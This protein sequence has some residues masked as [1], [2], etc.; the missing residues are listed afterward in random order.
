MKA[1]P[2]RARF[3]LRPANKNRGLWFI[4]LTLLLLAL[5]R[6]TKIALAQSQSDIPSYWQYSASGRIRHILNADID[7]NGIDDFVVADENGRVEMVGAQGLSAAGGEHAGR[8]R[9]QPSAAA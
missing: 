9:S 3:C 5:S 7:G 6:H 8:G 1:F 2:H 4:T